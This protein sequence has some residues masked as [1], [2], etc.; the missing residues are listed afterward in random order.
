MHHGAISLSLICP[1]SCI[2]V[3]NIC[4][5]FNNCSFYVCHLVTIKFNKDMRTVT[6][7]PNESLIKSEP[8]LNWLKCISVQYIEYS[9]CYPTCALESLSRE[10]PLWTC[11]LLCTPVFAEGV[12][13]KLHWEEILGFSLSCQSI[14]VNCILREICNVLGVHYNHTVKELPVL[15]LVQ[16]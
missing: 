3:Y 16:T 10:L 11:V 14:C 7:Q 1:F 6:F 8:D 2:L 13:Q 15:S 12:Q 4:E 9:K 5:T